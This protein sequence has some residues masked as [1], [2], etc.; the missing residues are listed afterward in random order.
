M[1]TICLI[2][3]LLIM[4]FFVNA[5]D[6]SANAVVAAAKMNVLYRGVNNPIEVAV[7]GIPSDKVSIMVTN[8]TLS[9]TAEGF[10]V[11]PGEQAES[12]IK[13]LVD[14]K[15]I[16][17]KKFRIKNIPEPIALFAGKHEGQIEK[18]VALKTDNLVADLKDFL[19]DLKFTIT[20]F[21]LFY[22]MDK[23]DIEETSKS[24][25]VTDKM[26]SMIAGMTP[27]KIIAFKDIKAVGPDGKIKNLDQIV[28]TIK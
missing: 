9:K 4:P 23:I 26:K 12:V 7:P 15:E 1:K 22:S 8:G 27:G 10:S 24:N 18:E 20:E 14:N 5:Q 17:E 28:L 19:W 13:V 25:K 2:F 3:S 6:N 16:S 11:S 21:T